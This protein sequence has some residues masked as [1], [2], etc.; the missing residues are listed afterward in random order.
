MT[1]TI[2]EEPKK[3]PTIN[4]EERKSQLASLKA[5]F[6]DWKGTLEAVQPDRNAQKRD[7]HLR[8]LLAMVKKGIENGHPELAKITSD[9]L[10]ETYIKEKELL[11]SSGETFS[12][13]T[14]IHNVIKLL[15]VADEESQNL[16]YDAFFEVFNCNH[17]VLMDGAIDLLEK[18]KDNNFRICLVRNSKLPEA[19][20]NKIL[21][22]YKADK[23]FEAVILGGDLGHAKPSKK[24]FEAAVN[25]L[26]LHDLHEKA[27]HEI[28]FVGNETEADI[29]GGKSMGWTT[30]LVRTTEQSSNGL[31]DLEVDNL[32]ELEELIFAGRKQET[33]NGKAQ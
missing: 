18:L 31:A 14:L 15:G 29:I 24:V 5:V 7:R 3:G 10:W 9:E 17:R 6:F 13:R 11:D 25:A 1:E 22:R 19:E 20:F 33:T 2:T 30:C 23:Y 4:S 16:M 21:E 28:L 27:P 8:P 12:M 32:F 26:K